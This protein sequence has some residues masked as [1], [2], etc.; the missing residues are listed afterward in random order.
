MEVTLFV[1]V[2]DPWA[3]DHLETPV[4]GA[5]SGQRQVEECQPIQDQKMNF[6]VAR[7][8][9]CAECDQQ[10]GHQHVPWTSLSVDSWAWPRLFSRAS[11]FGPMEGW[12]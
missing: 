9:A 2:Y 7:W 4:H 11:A 8:P 12:P 3:D 5:A 6:L 1:A 10:N